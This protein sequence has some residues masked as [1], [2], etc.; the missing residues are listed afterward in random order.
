MR[1]RGKKLSIDVWFSWFLCVFVLEF[2]RFMCAWCGF[3]MVW[4]SLSSVQHKAL[5]VLYFIKNENRVILEKPDYSVPTRKL[6]EMDSLGILVYID[7]MISSTLEDTNCSS[8]KQRWEALHHNGWQ[9]LQCLRSPKPKVSPKAS[10]REL[11]DRPAWDD[12]FG[13]VEASETFF[14]SAELCW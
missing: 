13:V 5:K 14:F 10:S 6:K 7:L 3:D 8:F 12:R 1:P 9:N 2:A 4:S 11:G